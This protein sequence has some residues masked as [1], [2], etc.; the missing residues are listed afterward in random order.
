MNRNLAASPAIN[1]TASPA[2]NKPGRD[3]GSP[4]K[5]REEDRGL[6]LSWVGRLVHEHRGYLLRV[7]RSEGLLPEDTFDVV[8]EAFHTFLVL[9]SARTFVDAA[10]DSRRLLVAIT[11]NAARNRRRLA[12]VARPHE[13][14]E[15]ALGAL[16]E[17]SPSVEVLLASAEETLRLHGCVASLGDLQRKVVTLR[18]LDE[19]D[20]E[21]VAR[22]LGLAPGHVAVLLHRAKAALLAC[23]TP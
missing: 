5:C 6:F 10:D 19:V 16:A 23:M 21:N 3:T 7:A 18:M 8:Q 4:C 9:P 1:P 17:P 11:R 20:G 2:R 22:S 12:A 15:G 13:S 14:G